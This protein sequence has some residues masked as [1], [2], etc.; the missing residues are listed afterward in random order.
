[1]VLSGDDSLQSQVTQ[2]LAEASRQERILAESK[3]KNEML[4]KD[5][6]L[7][8]REIETLKS[9]IQEKESSINELQLFLQEHNLIQTAQSARIQ[10]CDAEIKELKQEIADLKSKIN[11]LTDDLNR[12]TELVEQREELVNKANKS[13]ELEK[14][15]VIELSEK[16][17]E[18]QVKLTNAVNANLALQDCIQDR[19]IADENMLKVN[20]SLLD[21]LNNV[22]IAR[23][24]DNS[25]KRM[26]T[27]EK[28]LAAEKIVDAVNRFLAAAHEENHTELDN[29][30]D[31]VDFPSFEGSIRDHRILVET[32]TTEASGNPQ[33]GS[34]HTL[35]APSVD[36]TLDDISIKV[37]NANT[38]DIEGQMDNTDTIDIEGQVLN[39]IATDLESQIV[40]VTTITE[41]L[42]SSS[43][44]DTDSEDEKY[45]WTDRMMMMT[46][47]MP[48]DDLPES[49]SRES[50]GHEV[51][52]QNTNESQF[53][54]EGSL[55][56]SLLDVGFSDDNNN[57]LENL[58]N[59]INLVPASAPAPAPASTPVPTVTNSQTKHIIT[60]V[61]S[62]MVVIVEDIKKGNTNQ[63]DECNEFYCTPTKK[64]NAENQ[65]VISTSSEKR[66]KFCEVVTIINNNENA[67]ELNTNMNM[68][69]HYE[70]P[71]DL[72][73]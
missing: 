13:Y 63:E 11:M 33:R 5:L 26:K 71:C 24:N 40:K 35:S 55:K 50:V 30:L 66:T 68:T 28:S 38:M 7:T 1:M 9:T 15:T 65:E 23:N 36:N 2:L 16:L 43:N 32:P 56:G 70:S 60:S 53:A 47:Q 41:Y 21:I 45:K 34:L 14:K 4:S 59:E 39:T 51:T 61:M 49:D 18:A 3:A 10:K 72:Y 12:K 62:E 17:E 6:S 8:Q 57:K 31:A 73:E 46:T 52:N 27:N 69:I 44:S 29:V 54:D 67:N 25:S 19:T 64:R 58:E 37:V 42:S 22:N 48:Q 20:T